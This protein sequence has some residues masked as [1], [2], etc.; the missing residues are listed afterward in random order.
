MNNSGFF[1]FSCLCRFVDGIETE[2]NSSSTQRFEFGPSL[3]QS[4]P[5][6]P[7]PGTNA[8]TRQNVISGRK[9]Y[10]VIFPKIDCLAQSD[11]FWPRTAHSDR[12]GP[13]DQYV[14]LPTFFLTRPQGWYI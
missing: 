13:S 10:E 2:S 9:Y 7:S 5:P 11:L 12:K 3:P 1:F 8:T 14:K 6:S 4:G